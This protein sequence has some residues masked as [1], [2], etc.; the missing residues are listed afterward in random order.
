MTAPV[1]LCA[2]F[3]GTYSISNELCYFLSSIQ[4]LLVWRLNDNLILTT[5]RSYI[6]CFLDRLEQISAGDL[7]VDITP[8]FRI[9]NPSSILCCA[10]SKDYRYK[11]G[12]TSLRSGWVIQGTRFTNQIGRLR[13]RTYPSDIGCP[14]ALRYR[15]ENCFPLQ[16]CQKCNQQ[17]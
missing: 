5:K 6:R 12:G 11:S 10:A 13:V 9:R 17:P 4:G 7:P 8:T 1:C 3:Y 14:F 15:V 16:D 2:R